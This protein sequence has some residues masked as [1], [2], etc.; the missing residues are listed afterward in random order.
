MLSKQCWLLINVYY[1]SVGSSIPNGEF[2]IVRWP[3]R[4]TLI[5]PGGSINGMKIGWCGHLQQTRVHQVTAM[6]THRRKGYSYLEAGGHEHNR[7]WTTNSVTH[8]DPPVH[9]E[10]DDRCW[11]WETNHGMGGGHPILQGPLQ[12]GMELLRITLLWQTL[13]SSLTTGGMEGLGHLAKK[14]ISSFTEEKHLENLMISLKAWPMYMMR[15]QIRITLLP[16]APS[17]FQN[18]KLQ[19]DEEIRQHLNFYLKK[20]A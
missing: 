6:A 9:C 15:F 16:T 17:M 7:Y 8:F 4:T 5:L 10:D 19:T 20:R 3:A 14:C 18:Q 2:H 1:S 12:H 13:V 11:H